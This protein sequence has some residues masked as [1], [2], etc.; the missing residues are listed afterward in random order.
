MF[1]VSTALMHEVTSSKRA[2]GR[3]VLVVIVV[4]I[5]VVAGSWGVL[6]NWLQVYDDF[7]LIIFIF[8]FK[9]GLDFFNICLNI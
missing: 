4:I 6:G 1:N 3:S 7:K 9:L 2:I 8:H 5:L